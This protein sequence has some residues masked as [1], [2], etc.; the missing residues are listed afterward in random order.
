LGYWWVNYHQVYIV[1]AI[2]GAL[3]VLV[4]AVDIIK[5]WGTI[6]KEEESALKKEG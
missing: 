1:P 6:F 2:L 5:T 4:L 3:A